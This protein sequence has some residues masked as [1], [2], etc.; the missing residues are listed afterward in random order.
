MWWF[1]AWFQHF[2]ECYWI[3]E[4]VDSTLVFYTGILCRWCNRS[5]LCYYSQN[6]QFYPHN[7]PINKLDKV[8]W[9]LFTRA[10]CDKWNALSRLAGICRQYLWAF[11]T[12]SCEIL[13]I[14]CSCFS[15]FL[16]YRSP[17]CLQNIFVF[18]AAVELTWN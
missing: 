13:K 4:C 7:E 15:L 3:S 12:F 2:V 14:F 11:L 18:C 5:Y 6:V 9:L 1:E 16:T 17:T 8:P 10:I